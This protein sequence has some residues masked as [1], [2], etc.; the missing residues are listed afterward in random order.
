LARETARGCSSRAVRTK[1]RWHDACSGRG[2]EADDPSLRPRPAQPHGSHG[3]LRHV[4][5]CLLRRLRERSSDV[6]RDERGGGW[7]SH[8]PSSC[9]TRGR[10]RIHRSSSSGIPRSPSSRDPFSLSSPCVP[11][12]AQDSPLAFD[13]T[14]FAR[15]DERIAV[16]RPQVS[17]SSR[18]GRRRH[19]VGNA[20]RLS[21]SEVLCRSRQQAEACSGRGLRNR[22]GQGGR[23]GRSHGW[24]NCEGEKCLSIRRIGMRGSVPTRQLHGSG[25]P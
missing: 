19:V 12:G 5:R 11:V 23:S 16:A 4:S 22:L 10:A 21:S 7:Q 17:I 6:L 13:L 2:H 1:R 24:G 25:S 9:G 14:S 20:R 3:V 15:Q 8:A 18:A